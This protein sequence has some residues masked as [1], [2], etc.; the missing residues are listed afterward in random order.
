MRPKEDFSHG[1]NERLLVKSFYDSLTY[2]HAL[3][4]D[5]AGKRR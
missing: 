4:T 3:L 1:L 5:L 2:W